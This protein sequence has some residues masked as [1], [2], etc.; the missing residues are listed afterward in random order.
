MNL[1]EKLWRWLM[2]KEIKLQ[3]KTLLEIVNEWLASPKYQLMLKADK[4]YSVENDIVDRVL[5]KIGEGGSKVV[6][7][8]VANN[9]IVHA[10][11]RDLVDQKVQYLTGGDWSQDSENPDIELFFDD[12]FRSMFRRTA[13][14]AINKGIGWIH[15]FIDAENNLKLKRMNPEEIIP[16]WEDNDHTELSGVIRIFNKTVIINDKSEQI[17]YIDYYTLDGIK[18]YQL[19]KTG[20]IPISEDAYMLVNERPYMWTKLPFIPLKYNDDE[21][22]L[23]KV[24]KSPIDEADRS[25]SDTAN[26][27][28]N[29]PNG[30]HVISNAGATSATEFV[31]NINTYHCVILPENGSYEMKSVPPDIASNISHEE[32]L[33]KNIYS[34]GRGVDTNANIGANASS[35]SRQYLYASLDL[36]SNQLEQGCQD[37]L[38]LILWFLQNNPNNPVSLTEKVNF[39]FD[40]NMM[41]NTNQILEEILKMQQ[42]TGISMETIVA[43]VPGIENPLD[44]IAKYKAEIDE[45]VP[46]EPIL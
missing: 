45:E 22:S 6:A 11:Y 15:V 2:P 39:T 44:E 41:I 40:R 38:Q 10:F 9:K 16:L 13:K 5:Y 20:L 7:K 29:M 26:L 23:L 12:K 36:D 1:K 8:N 46:E 14:D 27:M 25:A 30:I 43:K 35:E 18:H 33:R 21:I 31:Q 19:Q 37:C 34:F 24:V 28:E 32:Q 4:Y 3:E 42:I 17:T